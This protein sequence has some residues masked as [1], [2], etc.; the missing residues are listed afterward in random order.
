MTAAAKVTDLEQM[1]ETLAQ[2]SKDPNAVSVGDFA[3]AVQSLQAELKMLESE[4]DRLGNT[5]GAAFDGGAGT[6]TAA[7]NA[8]GADQQTAAK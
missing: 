8:D 5:V 6:A 4:V 3:K 7:I 2:A 1:M